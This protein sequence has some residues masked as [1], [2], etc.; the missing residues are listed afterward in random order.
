MA[1]HIVSLT[2]NNRPG[3]LANVSELFGRIGCNIEKLSV[4][5]GKQPAVARMKVAVSIDAGSLDGVTARLAGLLDV[6]QV[7]TKARRH[8]REPVAIGRTS[9][10]WIVAYSLFI[11]LF[12]TNL[13]A[14]LYA[15]YRAQWHL[16]PAVMTLLFAAY[17]IVVIPVILVAGPLSDRIGRGKLLL[18]GILFALLGSICFL[19]ADGP[20]MLVLSRMLQ[21]VSVGIM[22]GVAVAAMTELG[23]MQARSQAALAGSAAVTAGNALGPVVSGFLGELAAHPT[24]LPFALHAMLVFPSIVGLWLIGNKG[25]RARGKIRIR[26][27]AVPRAIRPALYAA[28]GTSFISWSIMSLVTAILPAYLPDIVGES[29]LIASGVGLALVLGLSAWAQIRS[30]RYPLLANLTVGYLLLATGLA[31]LLAAAAA[32]SPALLALS[33]VMLGLGHGPC[34]ARSLRYVNESVPD[35]Y[36]GQA[37]SIYYG[38]TYMGVSLPILGL[39]IA[40]QRLGLLPAICIFAGV[41]VGLMAW[42]LYRWKRHLA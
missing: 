41:T 22:N 39:G 10:F 14:P 12:G 6:I 18:S 28:A 21:G 33:A 16:P 15:L 29:S 30:G 40:A 35:E 23:G 8:W 1:T 2:V 31:V 13:P 20:V 26:L 3:V 27:P 32:K 24:R 37:V 17:A 4:R 5:A 11:T 38:V 34:Y 42:S 36:R 7:K 25:E 19:L 9:A